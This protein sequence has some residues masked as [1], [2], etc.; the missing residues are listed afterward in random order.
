MSSQIL[1]TPLEVD[2]GQSDDRMEMS[3]PG[4]R[5]LLKRATQSAISGTSEVLFDDISLT[6]HIGIGTL[7]A[8][9]LHANEEFL[10]TAEGDDLST[11][12]DISRSLRFHQF[13]DQ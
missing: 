2:G 8:Q 1:L 11:L 7:Q 9:V 4:S 5:W 6:T 10:V 13:I 3:G 12:M